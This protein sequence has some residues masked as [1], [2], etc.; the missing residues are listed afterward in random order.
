[1]EN[2]KSFD[3]VIKEF[4]EKNA[5]DQQSL[6]QLDEWN[7]AKPF[8][9]ALGDPNKQGKFE[10]NADWKQRKSW[11]QP[12]YEALK[13][14]KSYTP[15]TVP[16]LFHY[17][18]YQEAIKNSTKS[19]NIS[20]SFGGK[21]YKALVANIPG[22]MPNNF[23]TS[24]TSRRYGNASFARGSSGANAGSVFG[25]MTG[26]ASIGTNNMINFDAIA[27]EIAEEMGNGQVI[28][29]MSAAS[30]TTTMPKTFATSA[31]RGMTTSAG[32]RL[33]REDKIDTKTGEKPWPW[34]NTAILTPNGR[35]QTPVSDYDDLIYDNEMVR[36][37]A[38]SEAVLPNSD[39][40]QLLI[41]LCENGV[42]NVDASTG[43]LSVNNGIDISTVKLNGTYTGSLSLPA[44]LRVI[45]E[46]LQTAEGEM[47]LSDWNSY[48]NI[49]GDAAAGYAATPNFPS[50]PPFTANT[51]Y[52]EYLRFAAF[53]QQAFGVPMYPYDKTPYVQA[54]SNGIRQ[55]LSRNNTTTG[56]G[57]DRDL[58]FLPPYLVGKY[59]MTNASRILLG[60][61][62]NFGN[63]IRQLMGI[64]HGITNKLNSIK[65]NMSAGRAI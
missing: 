61:L 45:V 32:D 59:L 4:S 47:M 18:Q 64:T 26:I 50:L 19:S 14:N 7:I 2:K 36:Y 27:W 38:L 55:A 20:V 58:Y 56:G 31:Y 44:S 29:T 17:E 21:N 13:D 40:Q 35:Y 65:H 46:K 33:E 37:C 1:M 24:V 11:A 15:G 52:S 6:E 9:Y 41:E 53:R 3:D 16:V 60:K 57:V 8:Q 42:I 51:N 5:I 10:N 48:V 43:T 22:L 63:T 49:D 23:I 12:Y 62:M 28:E 30:G 34:P 39:I 25:G 54:Y